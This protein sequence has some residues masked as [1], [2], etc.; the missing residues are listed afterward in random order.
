MIWS[1]EILCH[2][3]AYC[4]S[5][6]IVVPSQDE[7]SN[8]FFHLIG[9]RSLDIQLSGGGKETSF[10]CFFGLENTNVAAHSQ[11]PIISIESNF[12]PLLLYSWRKTLPE[13]LFVALFHDG[14]T[15]LQKPHSLWNEN[16]IFCPSLL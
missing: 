6:F 13:F 2:V 10:G 12:S 11:M 1:R 9:A 14:K 8:P 7:I 15:F 16:A 3:S 4:C 5:I